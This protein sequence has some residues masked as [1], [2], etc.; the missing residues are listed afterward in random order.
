MALSLQQPFGLPVRHKDA[1][2]PSHFEVG[3][4]FS[5]QVRG[6]HHTVIYSERGTALL[7][8]VILLFV[9]TLL[10]LP[11]LASISDVQRSMKTLTLPL[12]ENPL[13]LLEDRTCTDALVNSYEIV[14]ICPTEGFLIEA[15]NAS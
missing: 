9:T 6:K 8:A 2:S 12:T 15:P 13:N 4:E 1:N 11:N 3:C 10:I 7:D 5:V 14:R